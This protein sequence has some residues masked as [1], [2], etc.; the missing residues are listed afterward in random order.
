MPEEKLSEEEYRTM[1]RLLY[2]HALT[3]MDQFDDFKFDTQFG[4]IFVSISM[5]SGG[6]DDAFTDVSHLIKRE[7]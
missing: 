6:Y 4:K 3:E 1:F 7:P 5:K 2:R